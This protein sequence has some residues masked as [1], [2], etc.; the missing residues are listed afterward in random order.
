MPKRP[1]VGRQVVAQVIGPDGPV[2]VG[3]WEECPVN[4]EV[5]TE[6]YK[7]LDGTREIVITGNRYSGTL[8]RGH[9]DFTLAQTVWELANP[10]SDDPPR[11][12]LLMTIKYN[13]G[14][15]AQAMFKEVVFTKISIGVA[16][17]VIKDD[18]DWE[19]ESM[20]IL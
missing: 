16:R 2:E 4:I 17:G 15:T 1:I 18:I 12:V 10:G 11:H 20:E 14:T 7:P 6:E 8:R 9:Y 3:R 19:A 13:D 5:E